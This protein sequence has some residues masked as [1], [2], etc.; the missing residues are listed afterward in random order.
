MFFLSKYTYVHCVKAAQSELA[1]RTACNIVRAAQSIDYADPLVAQRKH[2]VDG[3]IPSLA[4]VNVNK[5]AIFYGI[6]WNGI[7]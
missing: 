1:V 7:H 4:K 5:V 2:C 6:V 3:E